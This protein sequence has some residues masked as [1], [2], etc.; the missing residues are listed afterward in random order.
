MPRMDRESHLQW[1]KDRAIK[2]C[3]IGDNNQAMNSFISDMRKHEETEDHGAIELLFQMAFMG[4]L[5]GGKMK[6]FINGFN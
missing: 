6:E 4:H 5:E 2:Y 1:C 3:E